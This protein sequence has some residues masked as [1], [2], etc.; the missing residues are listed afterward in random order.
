MGFPGAPRPAR[1]SGCDSQWRDTTG[2]SLEWG[3]GGVL[4]VQLKRVPKV[5]VHLTGPASVLDMVS[6]HVLFLRKGG[7]LH[8]RLLGK[9]QW[10]VVVEEIAFHT[11][12]ASSYGGARRKSLDGLTGGIRCDGSAAPHTA[13]HGG[14]LIPRGPHLLRVA[15]VEGRA[16]NLRRRGFKDQALARRREVAVVIYEV[17]RVSRVRGRTPLRVLDRRDGDI[18]GL[19]GALESKQV[20]VDPLTNVSAGAHAH[21]RQATAGDGMAWWRRHFDLGGLAFGSLGLIGTERREGEV[22]G[23]GARKLALR[24]DDDGRGGFR[25][26]VC[27]ERSIRSGGEELGKGGVVVTRV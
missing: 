6:L 11:R 14:G 18:L 10:E 13:R 26:L 20:Q 27:G 2:S 12:A 4:Q 17:V 24:H 9:L 21:S 23:K 19:V 7:R 5:I 1:D 16:A 15:A 8:F 25:S 22:L 3:D